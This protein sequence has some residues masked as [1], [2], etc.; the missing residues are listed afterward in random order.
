MPTLICQFCSNPF[1]VDK[2]KFKHRK[3]CSIRCTALKRW[4]RDKKTISKRFHDSCLKLDNGCW[5]WLGAL[6]KNGYGFMYVERN[7][8]QVHTRPHRVSF[9]L[10]NPKQLL[11]G[12]NVLHRCD[13]PWCVNPDHL[14]KGTQK[15]N[16][17]DCISKGR[18]LKRE[19]NLRYLAKGRSI[20]MNNLRKNSGIAS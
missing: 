7:G 8:K 9:E 6:D 2:Y 12:D 17:Y 19:D 5:K 15:D 1:P 18:F 20:R 10:Y 4:K 14:F 13:N 16:I 3:F 11:D